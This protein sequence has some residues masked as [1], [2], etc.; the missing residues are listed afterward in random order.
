M[1]YK[2]PR[3]ESP[4]ALG[5]EEHAWADQRQ[6][7]NNSTAQVQRSTHGLNSNIPKTAQ[8]QTITR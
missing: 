8:L 3:G 6:A 5:T 7:E 4:T 2:A 1:C